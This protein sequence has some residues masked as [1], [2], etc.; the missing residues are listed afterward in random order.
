MSPIPD[1]YPRLVEAVGRYQRFKQ[2]CIMQA[3]L[4]PVV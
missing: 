2:L 4:E 1:T 3:G